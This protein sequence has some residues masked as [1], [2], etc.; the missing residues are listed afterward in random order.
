MS[1]NVGTTRCHILPALKVCSSN[2]RGESICTQNA[3]LDRVT[4]CVKCPIAPISGT[5]TRPSRAPFDQDHRAF[6]SRLARLATVMQ[7]GLRD[8]AMWS[9]WRSG[10]TISRLKVVCPRA[11]RGGFLFFF[12][13]NQPHVLKSRVSTARVMPGSP[14]PH[15]PL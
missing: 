12:T 1:L 5:E 2:P 13:A 9:H 7:S 4:L 10:H 3:Y 6:P 8:T 14:S 15:L 11:R